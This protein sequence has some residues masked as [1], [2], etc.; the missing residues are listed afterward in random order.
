MNACVHNLIRKM[1][2]MNVYET[3][4]LFSQFLFKFERITFCIGKTKHLRSSL[5]V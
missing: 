4:M 2:C 5:P 3:S 1:K